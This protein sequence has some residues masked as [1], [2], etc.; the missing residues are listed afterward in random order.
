MPVDFNDPRIIIERKHRHL[1]QIRANGSYYISDCHPW[2]IKE[3]CPRE[4]CPMR[5]VAA[6]PEPT[7]NDYVFQ[8]NPTGDLADLLIMLDRVN[9]KSQ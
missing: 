1:A 4:D 8:C 3:G 2:A 9:I 6:T 7:E 5:F